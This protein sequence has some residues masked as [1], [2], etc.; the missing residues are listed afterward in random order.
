[1]ENN[2][3]KIENQQG[4]AAKKTNILTDI[5]EIIESTL[6][7]VFIIVLVFTYVLHPVN[8]V[9]HSMVPTLNKDYDPSLGNT[10]KIFMSTVFFDVDYGDILVINKDVNY[11]LDDNGNP[12]IPEGA[13]SNAIGECIIKRVIAT[14][15]QTI[16]IRDGK[17]IVDD[18]VLN[19]PYINTDATTADLGYGAFSDQ[20]PITVPEGYFF[21]MGDN[22]NHSTD[23][24]ARSV[25]LVKKDQIYGK[26]L[27]RYSPLKD[28][29]ILTDSW[30]GPENG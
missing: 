30:K 1:M 3:E 22:R 10:D 14:G 9:G 20:Y 27:V 12:Y 16:D 25:G 15:G 28:F 13:G 29:D 17:V 7:T 24:R 19:E 21:V 5:V 6:V 2:N 18:K 23:S 4:E 11:L 8:I 26:A